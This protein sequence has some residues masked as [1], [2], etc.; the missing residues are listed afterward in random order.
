MRRLAGGAEEA[1][2]EEY[3]REVFAAFGGATA[4]WSDLA[5]RVPARWVA[6]LGRFACKSAWLRRRLVF[7]AAFGMG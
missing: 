6:A 4:W 3:R 2:A 1:I 7:E 5:L